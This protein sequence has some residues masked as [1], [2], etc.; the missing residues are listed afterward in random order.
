MM[1]ENLKLSCW[2][3]CD[4]CSNGWNLNG[5][6]LND[7]TKPNCLNL[8][9]C[10]KPNYLMNY[11]WTIPSWMNS[12][13]YCL[14]ENLI[15]G[16]LMNCW[17]N[18]SMIPNCYCSNGS[19]ILNWMNLSEKMNYDWNSN[20]NCCCENS[21]LN[22]WTTNGSNLNASWIPN[23]YCSNDLNLSDYY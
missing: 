7:S 9:G 22:C 23:C 3:N 13:G 10:W 17:T 4:C 19:T 5:W 20:A 21:I 16:Y 12:N 1:N 8:N 11:D 2:K 6:N 14:N 18:G 15:A